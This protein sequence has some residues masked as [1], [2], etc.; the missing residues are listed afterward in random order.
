MKVQV[1]INHK[2]ILETPFLRST[3]SETVEKGLPNGSIKGLLVEKILT[4]AD[5]RNCFLED[6]G[7][8]F[9]QRSRGIG[10]YLHFL[11]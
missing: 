8:I 5:I 7:A 2:R 6:C 10:L 9:Y 4:F 11:S 1:I 3:I